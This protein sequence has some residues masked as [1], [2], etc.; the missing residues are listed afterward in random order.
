M[1]PKKTPI[2]KS[3]A[4]KEMREQFYEFEELCVERAL[5]CVLDTQET[6]G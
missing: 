3:E 2:S 4:L 6:K 1:K 5:K